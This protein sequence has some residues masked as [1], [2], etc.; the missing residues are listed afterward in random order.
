MG[1]NKTRIMYRANLG[2]RLLEKYLAMAVNA[3][4]VWVNAQT[5][6]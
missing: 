4:F 1:A 5:T 2:F 3:G 6:F